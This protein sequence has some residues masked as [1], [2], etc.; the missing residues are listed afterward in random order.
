MQIQD[1]WMNGISKFSA[2]QSRPPTLMRPGFSS[3][4]GDKE[5][6]WL[7]AGMARLALGALTSSGNKANWDFTKRAVSA[8]IC[9][10]LHRVDWLP[11]CQ[12]PPHEGTWLWLLRV[13]SM[14][15]SLQW[16]GVGDLGRFSHCRS[17]WTSSAH[18]HRTQDQRKAWRATGPWV[19]KGTLGLDAFDVVLL[20]RLRLAL[21]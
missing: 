10:M 7:L 16:Q 11:A 3:Y 14:K 9:E 19:G 17:E 6:K 1:D 15:E 5:C 13:L 12:R 21:K 2:L 8:T 4:S 18:S 20:A